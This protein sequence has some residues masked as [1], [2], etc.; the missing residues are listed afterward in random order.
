[1]G[2]TRYSSRRRCRSF[3]RPKKRSYRRFRP[4]HEVVPS[5]VVFTPLESEYVILIPARI[6]ISV[7]SKICLG[8][9]CHAEQVY[10]LLGGTTPFIISFGS[11]RKGR[12]NINIVYGMIK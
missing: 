1:M 8:D 10:F 5:S 3:I 6:V 12:F 7:A 4:K 2:R 11:E 9:Q